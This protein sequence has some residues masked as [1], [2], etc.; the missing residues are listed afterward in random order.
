[1]GFI[2]TVANIATIAL[3]A[4]VFANIWV[5]VLTKP[6]EI[7]RDIPLYYGNG[8]F[9][10]IMSC[11]NCLSGWLSIIVVFSV[12]V[13]A[14]LTNQTWIYYLNQSIKIV[15]YTALAGS[16]GIYGSMMIGNTIK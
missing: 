2:L 7:L 8:V 16:F 13:S 14:T 1:M 5:N 15:A 9:R 10:R 6:Q 11:E 4:S 12:L 3:C